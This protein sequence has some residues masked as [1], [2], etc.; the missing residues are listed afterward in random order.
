GVHAVGQGLKLRGRLDGQT[1]DLLYQVQ[2]QAGKT[3]VIDMVSPDPNALD[4]YLVLRD[5][6]GK[7]LAEDD[8]SGDGRNARITFRAAQGGTFRI[9]ASSSN[10]GRGAFTLTVRAQPLAAK[11][12]KEVQDKGK[13]EAAKLKRA[14]EHLR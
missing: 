14:T 7:K 3:Y 13:E 2:L 11:G 9:Q 8:D 5:A 10:A 12:E 1:T 6:A 4:P